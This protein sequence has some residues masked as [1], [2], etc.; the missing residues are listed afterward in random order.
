MQLENGFDLTSLANVKAACLPS[1]AVPRF[2]NDVSLLEILGE[3]G[4]L[5]QISLKAIISGWGALSSGGT[6]PTRLQRANVTIW[7][8]IVGRLAYPTR[9]TKASFPASVAGSIDACQAWEKS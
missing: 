4:N 7:P 2:V 3:W 5:L 9:W 8:N 1:R 6:Y